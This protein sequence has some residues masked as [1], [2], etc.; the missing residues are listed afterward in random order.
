MNRTLQLT[1]A[2]AL[3]QLATACGG[4]RFSPYLRR[5]AQVDS[6]AGYIYGRFDY[7]SSGMKPGYY[8]PGM[9]LVLASDDD[10][11]RIQFLDRDARVYAV[12][13]GTYSIKQTVCSNPDGDIIGR[14][15][16]S[17]AKEVQSF[18]VEPG[19]AYYIGDFH[20]QTRG[21]GLA[22]SCWIDDF[23]NNYEEATAA[24]QKRYPSLKG[25][26]TQDVS[27]SLLTMP[28]QVSGSQVSGKGSDDS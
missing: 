23:E 10:E 24:F 18:R 26:E 27:G 2:V 13:P 8:V 21:D 7:S 19:K 28:S 4:G 6:E 12:K 16:G 17:S 15:P 14:S 1:C 11:L 3:L 9:G 20:G 5:N 22:G 25:L